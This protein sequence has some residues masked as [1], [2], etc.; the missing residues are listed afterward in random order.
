MRIANRLED[1]PRKTFK[2]FWE[3]FFGFWRGKRRRSQERERSPQEGGGCSR[4]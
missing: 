2:M 3:V 1:M 4:R